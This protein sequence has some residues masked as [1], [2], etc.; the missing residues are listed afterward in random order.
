MICL[1]AVLLDVSRSKL[2]LSNSLFLWL[3]KMAI[4]TI[5][6]QLGCQELIPLCVIK[7][8][9]KKNKESR[10][11]DQLLKRVK[12]NRMQGAK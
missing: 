9:E 6:S 12:I 11:L 2:L 1:G 5:K 10:Q 8:E 7:K 4:S 3:S